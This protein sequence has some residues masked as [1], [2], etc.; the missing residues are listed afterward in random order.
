MRRAQVDARGPDVFA[1][2]D[3]RFFPIA[4]VTPPAIVQT[5]TGLAPFAHFVA[6]AN[7]TSTLFEALTAD[8]LRA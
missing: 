6:S 4:E 7:A 3:F 8:G 1:N 5:S 2:R